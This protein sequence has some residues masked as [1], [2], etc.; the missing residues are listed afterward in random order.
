M[1]ATAAPR[2]VLSRRAFLASTALVA[3]AVLLGGLSPE[4]AGAVAVSNVSGTVSVAGG[5]NLRT[6]PGTGY[7]VIRTLPN[8]TAL[9]ISETSGDWLKVIALGST[10]WVNSWYVTLSGN[11]S[12]TI[13]RGNANRKMVALTFDAGTDLGYT[14]RIINTLTAYKVTASFGM[15]GKWTTSY[16]AH[17]RRVVNAGY[18]LI[19]HTVNHSSLTGR[20]LGTASISPARRLTELIACENTFRS[21][22]G[23][24]ARPYWRPPYGDYDSGVL[25]DTGAA[26]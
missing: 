20:S 1:A 16:P 18:Q 7:R 26:G 2:V 9:A 10:G 12:R 6:G 3:P 13:H 11:A 17:A 23:R 22:A 8:G 19:N 4:P 25:R 21:T 14:D 24:S 15:T 5:L